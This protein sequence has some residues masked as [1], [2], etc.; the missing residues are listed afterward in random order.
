MNITANA[1]IDVDK[2]SSGALGNTLQLGNLATAGNTITLTNNAGATNYNLSV[3]TV[4]SS[5]GPTFTNNMVDGTATLA[6]LT[7]TPAS[8]QTVTFNGTSASAITSVGPISQ[9]AANAL[10]LTQSGSGSLLLTASN[11]YTGT[12]TISGGTLQVGNGG[13]GE[14]INSTSSVALSNSAALVFNHADSVIF[15]KAIS[16]L[17]SLTQTG[18]G[19]LTLSAGNTYSGTTTLDDGELNLGIADL[20]TP[21]VL[22]AGPLGSR[23]QGAAGGIVLN[24]GYLQYSSVNNYRLFRPLQHGRQPAYQHRH[25]RPERDL[26]HGPD[27]SGRLAHGER[28]QRHPRHVG[29]AAAESYTGGTHHQGRRDQA[30]WS[31]RLVAD[32]RGPDHDRRHV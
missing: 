20:N 18:T 5:A 13:N 22:G 1:A 30:E 26:C 9:N 8:G 28:H 15:A 4:T 17:G 21:S 27:Q 3:G 12:T 11:T 19:I 14:S 29:L 32:G 2:A 16:G 6:A 7:L 10:A 31:S 23:L 25:Q 24:G